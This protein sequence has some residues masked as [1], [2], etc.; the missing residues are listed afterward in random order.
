MTNQFHPHFKSLFP[1]A[2]GLSQVKQVCAAGLSQVKKVC[3]AGWSQDKI[4]PSI[5]V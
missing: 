3:T 4:Y 1:S 5:H 2:R